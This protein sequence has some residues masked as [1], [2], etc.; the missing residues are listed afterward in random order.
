[1]EAS[2]GF[3]NALI[4]SFIPIFIA[5]DP[6]GI[7]PLL[8]GMMDELPGHERREIIG[9]SVFTAGHRVTTAGQ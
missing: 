6:F 4:L 2:P 8:V 5:I 9:H 1:M 3:F 7:L